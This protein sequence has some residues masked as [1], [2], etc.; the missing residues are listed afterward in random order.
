MREGI[1]NCVFINV[2]GYNVWTFRSC[3]RAR[4]GDRAYRQVS[5]QQGKNVTLCLVVSPTNSLVHHTAQLGG[6][7]R[8]RLNDFLVELRQRMPEHERIFFIYDNAPVHRNAVNPGG[9]TELKPLPPYSP[10][11]NIVEQAISA[12]KQQL[13]QTYQGQISNS[14]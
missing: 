11:L 10:F 6:M 4:V 8:E 12:L 9:R 7:N 5:G 1:I 3:G 13:K 2:Y 14:K